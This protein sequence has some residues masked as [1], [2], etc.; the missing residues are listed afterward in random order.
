M[1]GIFVLAHLPLEVLRRN[2]FLYEMVLEL[3]VVAFSSFALAFRVFPLHS[4]DV[5]NVIAH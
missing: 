4:R 3:E 2:Y 5:Y 1:A